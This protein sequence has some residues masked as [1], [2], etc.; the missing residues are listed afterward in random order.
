MSRLVFYYINL[1]VL[2]GKS[3]VENTIGWT[4]SLNK[5]VDFKLLEMGRYWRRKS[6]FFFIVFKNL[7]EF[8]RNPLRSM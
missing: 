6:E 5:T 2:R 1:M 4:E 8:R 7:K 3:D